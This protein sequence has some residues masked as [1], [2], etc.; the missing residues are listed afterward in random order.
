MYEERLKKFTNLY[1]S[2]SRVYGNDKV[3][4]D[5]VKM[6]A[7]SIYNSF[8]KNQEMEQEYLKTINSY[9][10][11]HH[12]TF[13]RMFG[14]LIMMY[15]EAGDIIDILSTFYTRKNLG[16]SFLGQVFTPSHISD[17]MAEISCEDENS[18]KKKINKNGFITMLEPSCGAGRYGTFISKGVE[19]K[20]YKLSTRVTC[21]CNRFIRHMCI[22]DIYS[23]SFVW[24]TCDCILWKYSN[25]RNAI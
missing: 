13:P 10:K 25:T 7:I 1:D 24:N 4:R 6:C 18:L 3:F 21:N 11:E 22:N 20:K 23:I 15:E 17:F 19:K 12:S 2:L 9:R 5:F 14:E 8:S 16:N